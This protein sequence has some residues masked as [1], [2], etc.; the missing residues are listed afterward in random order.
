MTVE[1]WL[2]NNELGID[3]WEKKYRYK[4]ES[5]I[6]WLDRVS[7]QNED[8]KKMLIEKKFLFG[9][10]T[11]A[12]RRTDN[13]Q[14]LSNCYSSGY[15]PDSVEGML[16]LNK[17]L[18]LTFKSGGGQGVS[19]TKVRPKGSD[20]K[21]GI[22]KSDGIVPFMEI[23]NQTTSSISQGGNRKG[24]ILMS[25]SVWH[26]EIE[27]FISI[28]DGTSKITKANLSVEID[29]EFMKLVEDNVVSFTYKAFDKEWT[30]NPTA[31]YNNIMQRA[32]SSAE[33]GVIFTDMF[34]KYNLMEYH[35]EY[36][37]I[38]CNPCGEQ[39]LP[40]DG[41]CNLGTINISEYVLNPYTKSAELDF[42]SFKKDIVT[43]VIEL[44][45]IVDEGMEHHALES[46]REMAKNY[47]NVG[48][49]LMGIATMFMKMGIVYG[50]KESK[51]FMD[52]VSSV[53]LNQSLYASAMLAKELGSYPKCEKE[54]ILKSRIIQQN[55][56]EP[57]V[58]DLIKEY[59]LRNCSLIS[60]PPNGSTATMLQI[61]TGIEP[62]YSL[63]YTRKT[64]SLH[65][66]T[67]KYYEIE[68]NSSKTAR[69]VF[70]DDVCVSA[71][72][73]DWKDRVELQGIMQKYVD[74]AISST[75]NVKE[76]T[77]LEELRELYLYA[78]K[79]N[80]KGITIYREGSFE[81]VLSSDSNNKKSLELTKQE[82]SRGEMKK[83]ADDTI[84]YPH[85]LIIGCGKLK[86][87]IGYSE[88]E[89]KIQ[90]LYVIK[91]GS[92]GCEKNLQSVAIYMSGILRLGGD[93]NLL[94]KSINGV[95][96]CTS[97]ATSRARGN[98]VCKGST[99]SSAILNTL[100]GFDKSFKESQKFIKKAD[101]VQNV[102]SDKRKCPECGEEMSFEGGC[103]SCTY[104]GY[105]K[106][107]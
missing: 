7:G 83:I 91:S 68:V 33:P 88:S 27:T 104:C 42:K 41:A 95:S 47:R 85:K 3:I 25:L 65:G 102:V 81:A 101:P 58:L 39:P 2:E 19:L 63:K 28:K 5:F 9:G 24:A 57:V 50:S 98:E 90:D 75:V 40:K 18:A 74:T 64:E 73:I 105:S 17:N 29:D 16:E 87:M 99:C 48:L 60:F 11:L 1:K 62:Y 36:E 8:M 67:D 84:Y 13:A 79:N 56:I 6:Q 20:V 70:G 92:G 72:S 66:D 52:L 12:S 93:L 38:I 37:I 44:D 96:G 26:P 71:M 82:L 97:F 55:N 49:G 61:S 45:R 30:I 31:I 34:R 100:K 10:R 69:E 94:E 21:G 23:F 51:D 46:Q 106:C 54:S 35:S 78:W 107:E 32:W 59:G 14:S 22:F 43:A 15:A 103:I 76:E 4:N 80:I 53:L 77:T 86:L 89:N